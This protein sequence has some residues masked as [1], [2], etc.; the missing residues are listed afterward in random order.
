MQHFYFL[1]GLG[2]V[3][4]VF[5]GL[6]LFRLIRR[7]R[8]LPYRLDPYLLAPRQRAF[9][10]AL[11]RAV[12][13]GYRVYPKVRAVDVIEVGGRLDRQARERA[14][15]RLGGNRFDF[16]VCDRETSALACAVNLAP[17]SRLARRP[18]K[19]VLDRICAAVNLPFVRFRESDVYSVVEIEER[20][21]AAMQR[22]RLERKDDGLATEDT[23]AA[24]QGLSE[25]IGEEAR[26]GRRRRARP[27]VAPGPGASRA[28]VPMP[29]PVR[30]EPRLRVDDDVDTGPAFQISLEDEE[31]RPVTRIGRV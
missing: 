8:G 28:P 20:V 13:R 17:P 6:S 12:G 27:A 21:F 4:L 30:T 14:Y 18:R 24:L 31:Q 1:L 22:P 26:P 9:Q 15:E 29:P 3:V 11:E 25:V 2:A 19:D 7:S 16:L 10:A 23:R 5:F